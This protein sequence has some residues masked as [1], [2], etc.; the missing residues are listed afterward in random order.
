MKL[1]VALCIGTHPFFSKRQAHFFLKTSLILELNSDYMLVQMSELDCQNRTHNPAHKRS[2]ESLNFRDI[3]HAV[4]VN[5][6][7]MYAEPTLSA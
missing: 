3:D 1:T 7:N 2:I 6:Y 5:T 4:K